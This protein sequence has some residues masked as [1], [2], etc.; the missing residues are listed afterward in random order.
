MAERCG[1]ER[2]ACA[3]LTR[4]LFKHPCRTP[5][6]PQVRV[7]SSSNHVRALAAG[8]VD[9]AVGWSGAAQYSAA[10]RLHWMQGA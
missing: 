10:P 9:A 4:P 3:V 6:R 8:E 5:A 7:F 1:G 2:A